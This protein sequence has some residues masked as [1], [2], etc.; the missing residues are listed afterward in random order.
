MKLINTDMDTLFFSGEIRPL[1]NSDGKDVNQVGLTVTLGEKDSPTIPNH[2]TITDRGVDGGHLVNL[3]LAKSEFKLVNHNN[4]PILDLS[5]KKRNDFHSFLLTG[6]SWGNMTEL[7][8]VDSLILATPDDI[9]TVHIIA[10][11]VTTAPNGLHKI[12][13]TLLLIPTNAY[14]CLGGQYY[15]V[16]DDKLCNQKPQG[17]QVSLEDILLKAHS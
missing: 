3:N 4:T 7:P 1:T 15:Q 13:N 16:A 8:N 5:K 14:Y 10:S 12:T 11:G 17:I 9:H 2:F 6:T